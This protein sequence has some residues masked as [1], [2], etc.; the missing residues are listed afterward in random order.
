MFRSILVHGLAGGAFVGVT[1]F[2]VT[3]GVGDHVPPPW[4]MVI[5][6]ANM[7]VAL[8]AI[9]VAIKRRRDRDL[10]GIIRFWSA[11][12]MGLSISMIA[13]V[14]YVAA[15]D[16]TLAIG[17]IDFGAE[18]AKAVML[19][20]HAKGLSGPALAAALAKAETFRAQYNN[21]MVRWPMTFAE[22]FPVGV[23]VSIVSAALLCRPGFL[24]ARD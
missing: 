14:L 15:W 10:G 4:G 11:M 12:A 17:H 1:L 7:L 18:Y 9:F 20:A 13:G 2:A 22:I 24:P 6:Y 5:G 3:L 21:P 16:L 23:I 8:S 19:K